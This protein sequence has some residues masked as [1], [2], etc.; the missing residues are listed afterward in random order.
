[1][2]TGKL[3]IRVPNR[4]ELLAIKA[5]E[6]EYDEL[7]DMADGLI[8]SIEEKYKTSTLSAHP[9]EEKALEVLIGIRE[10]LYS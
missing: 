5:G 8:A 3:T 7:L 6:R 10:V 2:A 1:M 4:D 9:D